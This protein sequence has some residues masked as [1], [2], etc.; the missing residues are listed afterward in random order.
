[1]VTADLV[2]RERGAALGETNRA[3][4][5][6]VVRV[7]L[8][9]EREHLA[10]LCRELREL[11]LGTQRRLRRVSQSSFVRSFVVAFL[12]MIRDRVKKGSE[13]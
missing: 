6:V 4:L 9:L 10:L 5:E 13:I 11:V 1:M 3:T 8:V 12:S 2:G 7:L